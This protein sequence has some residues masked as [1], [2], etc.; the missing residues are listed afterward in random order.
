MENFAPYFPGIFLSYAAFLLAIASPGPNIL[1][2]MGTS[3][4]VSKNAGVAL[5]MGVAIGSF[6]WGMLTILGLSALLASY[7]YAL[8]AIKIFG[9]VYLLWLAYKAFKSATSARD[10]EAKQLAGGERT[11][12]GY[13]ARG[14]MIQMTN[15]KA[16]L[17]WI[18]IISLGLANNA[19][20][21]VGIVIVLGTFVL[22]II[23]HLLYAL[24]F[25]SKKMVSL[26]GKARRTIQTT[27][28]VFFTIAGL[29]MLT[30]RS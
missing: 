7:A 21:W 30:S 19:P 17:A 14:Y 13:L 3:M 26:Y 2:I 29:K 8:T 12:F 24:V 5:A 28:G 4:S 18:A 11:P 10:I 15:P 16:A 1:A 25:S 27:L 23:I 6:T 20:T 9:G 22:S